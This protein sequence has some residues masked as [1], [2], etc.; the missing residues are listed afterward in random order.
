MKRFSRSDR[1]SGELVK[2]LSQIIQQEMKDPRLGFVSVTRVEVA[3]DLRHANAF[4]SVMGSKEEKESTLKALSS[5]AGFIRTLISKRM[6]MRIIPDFVFKLD[7]S[8]E[9]GARIQELLRIALPRETQGEDQEGE[10]D[11]EKADG[12]GGE[13]E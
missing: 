10:A 4:V 6:K 3:K 13:K 5:G 11:N 8:I 9:Y 2:E 1:V 12:R 7:D